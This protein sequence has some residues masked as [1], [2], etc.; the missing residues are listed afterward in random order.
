MSQK[1]NDPKIAPAS[2]LSDKDKEHIPTVVPQA[3]ATAKLGDDKMIDA[4]SQINTT[5][6]IRKAESL[7]SQESEI[8]VQHLH[9]E[10]V[11]EKQK[12]LYLR[13]EYGEAR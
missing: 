10:K 9:E 8:K 5:K 12:T 6:M 13:K 7:L 4:E 2:A 1:H 3:E 11:E